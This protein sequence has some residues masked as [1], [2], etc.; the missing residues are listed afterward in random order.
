MQVAPLATLSAI[1]QYDNEPVT[2]LETAKGRN[3]IAE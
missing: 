2:E 1:E 3:T